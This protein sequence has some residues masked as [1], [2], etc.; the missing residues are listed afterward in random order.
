[1]NRVSKVVR[2]DERFGVLEGSFVRRWMRVYIDYGESGKFVIVFF[3]WVGG[4]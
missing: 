3:G 1:M 4:S 2:R